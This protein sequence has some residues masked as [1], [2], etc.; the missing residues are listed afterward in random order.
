M[1]TITGAKGFLKRLRSF[2]FFPKAIEDVKEKETLGAIVTI[3]GVLV[4]IILLFAEVSEYRS[5]I[6]QD[7]IVVDVSRQERMNIELDITFIK[8]PCKDVQV[9]IVDSTGQDDIVISRD[10]QKIDVDGEKEILNPE[11]RNFFNSFG[12]MRG[13]ML[14]GCR[15]KGSAVVN[16]V[17]GNLHIAAGH[18]AQQDHGEHK[19]HTHHIKQQDLGVDFSH[20]VNRLAFGPARAG[21]TGNPLDGYLVRKRPMTQINYLLK[22]VPTTWDDSSGT[23]VNSHQYSVTENIKESQPGALSFPLPGVFIKWD[24]S[25]FII[26]YQEVSRGIAHL[27]TRICAITGGTFVVLGLV[28]Q[29]IRVAYTKFKPKSS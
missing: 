3:I 11:S 2:D 7:T 27:L 26:K 22:V 17:E 4:M 8:L 29:G 14:T 23:V 20:R 13:A 5:S 24:I 10:I 12:F 16:R 19:H 18:G 15:V 25:P 6:T 21:H 28:Y 9:D 1:H